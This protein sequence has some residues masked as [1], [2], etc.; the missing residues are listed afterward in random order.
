M[1][2]ERE[3]WE[4]EK[5]EKEKLLDVTG[6]LREQL[7]EKENEVKALL[8]K[9][10]LAVQEATE[11]LN[12]SH[13]QQIKLLTEKHQQEANKKNNVYFIRLECS[14]IIVPLIYCN[15]IFI[16]SA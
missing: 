16:S 6:L 12:S 3:K 8:E 15:Y 1:A 14:S 9:Q 10:V 4:T 2:D 11:K 5:Q 7:K 13:Q